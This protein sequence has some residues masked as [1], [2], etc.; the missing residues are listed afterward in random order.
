MPTVLDWLSLKIPR[1]CDGASLLPF[2]EG[3]KPA[4][5]RDAVFFEQDFR[6]VRTQKV[7]TALGISSDQCCYAAI[8][9]RHFKYVHFAALPPLLFDLEVDPNETTNLA[10]DPDYAPVMLRYARKMLD[11]RLSAAERTMTNMHVGS[12]GVFSRE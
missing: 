10:G 12:G 11:W 4:N 2:L 7:E 1:T 9:D 6:S 8:R 3:A 5:W